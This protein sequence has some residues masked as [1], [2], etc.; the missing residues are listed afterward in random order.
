VADPG[1]NEKKL[2]DPEAKGEWINLYR[3]CL[4]IE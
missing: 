3:R 2:Y 1:V 4:G